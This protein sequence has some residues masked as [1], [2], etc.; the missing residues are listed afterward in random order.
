[1]TYV[2]EDLAQMGLDYADLILIHCPSMTCPP[3]K[4]ATNAEIQ[5]T[6]RGLEDALHQGLTR[7]IGVSNFGVDDL[8]AILDL[9]NATTPAVNQCQMSVGSHDDATIAFCK[10]NN[11]AYEAYSPLG[12][13][14][15]NTSDPRIV[16]IA[17]N[18]P[19]K[20]VFQICLRWIVQQD[21]LL[22]VS[23]T[24]LAHDLSDLDLFDF[25]LTAEEMATLSAI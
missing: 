13:G 19:G 18:H 25:E 10:Q 6:W 3:W 20:S 17:A 16:K 5:D 15:L 11:I 1:M 23:S 22:A 4:H 24:K 8:Q 7:A 9:G 14:S 2:K 12:R 21:C